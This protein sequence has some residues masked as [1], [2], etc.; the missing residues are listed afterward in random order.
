MLLLFAPDFVVVFLSLFS[1]FSVY[2]VRPDN[3][4]LPRT[5]TTLYVNLD[6]CSLPCEKL[7]G[8][9]KPREPPPRPRPQDLDL[10]VVKIQDDSVNDDEEDVEA[11][12]TSDDEIDFAVERA[13]DN[14]V[15]EIVNTFF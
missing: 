12:P 4:L 15:Q 6:C 9:L 3:Y 14:T 7:Y 11:F 8:S 10:S 1:P 5:R 2:F 13:K